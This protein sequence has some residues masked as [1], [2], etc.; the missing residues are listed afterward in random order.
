MKIVRRISLALAAIVALV[1]AGALFYRAWWQ[2]RI[3][4]ALRITS[5]NGVD[6]A[7]FINI[8]G[9]DQWITVRG[10]N[11]ANPIILF[12]HGGPSEA[13]SPF[14]SLYRPFEK[15]YVFVQWDQPGAGRTYI[16]AGQHQSKLTLESMADDGIAV[17]K[18]LHGEL[19]GQK[20]ILIGQDWGGL[21]G[22]RMI[23]QRPDL[24]T[25]FVGTGQ[26]VSLFAQQE[27]Q[28]EYTRSRAAASHNEKVL[29]SLS[30]IG[31]PPYRNLEAY[32]RFAEYFE[33]VKPQ[34]DL[35]S[36]GRLT[37]LLGVTPS[38]TI[39]DVYYWIK[40]LRSGEELLN[41]TMMSEDLL[42]TAGVFSLPV[43]F[44]QGA[45]DII[46][47]TSLVSEYVSTIQAPVKNLKIVPGAAHFVM[48]TR[49]S[50]FL[51]SLREDMRSAT[52]EH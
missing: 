4:N 28:Y 20:I 50:E 27:K 19:P 16:K 5:P 33:P 13:N 6:E 26:I 8:D 35:A 43:F 1:V 36:E 51:E 24:F 12:L 41:P 17:A 37:D 25:A 9:T 32:R 3:A 48:W 40:A 29:T 11:R 30:Q 38:L 18:Y 21:L 39:V 14:A 7:K 2:H 44:I 49:P 34:E 42:K 22:L 47:P 31:P 52:A 46:T 23:R 45:D 10:E 15:D